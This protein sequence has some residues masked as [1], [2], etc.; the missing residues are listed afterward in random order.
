MATSRTSSAVAFIQYSQDRLQAF[1][2]GQTLFGP[3]PWQVSPVLGDFREPINYS[4]A[5]GGKRIRPVMVYAAAHALNEGEAAKEALDYAALAVELVHTY[6]LIHDDL[7]AMDNDDLRRGRPTL[8]KA[9]DEATAILAGDGL[10][11]HAFELLTN[12]TDLSDSRKVLMIKALAVAAG[13]M[14]MVGGQ[15]ID[16][17]ST[18]SPLTLDSLQT[19]H[20]LK[21]GAL[22]RAAL[23]LGGIAAGGSVKDMEVLD[24]YGRDIGLAFQVIDDILDVESDTSTLG[25]TQGKDQQANKSTYVTLMGIDAAKEE[26]DRLLQCALS[27]LDQLDSAANPLRDL[28]TYIVSRDR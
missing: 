26:A 21:T 8:H 14:G 22:I 16:I 2:D 17:Q 23:A 27:A 19:M 15:F 1:L 18:G 28:A 20:S 9:F 4:L 3:Q 6:S 13:P 25:K 12:I 10:Q 24:S 7:P 5:N 11:T